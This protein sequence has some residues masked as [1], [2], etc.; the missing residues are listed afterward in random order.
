MDVHFTIGLELLTS[1]DWPIIYTAVAPKRP[2]DGMSM[3]VWIHVRNV[4]RKKA[5][6]RKNAGIAQSPIVLWIVNSRLHWSRV[7]IELDSKRKFERISIYGKKQLLYIV[8][9]KSNAALLFV[10]FVHQLSC[11][12]TSAISVRNIFSFFALRNFLHTCSYHT[13]VHT[14]Y[15]LIENITK[16]ACE[17]E[18]REKKK[19]FQCWLI[20]FKWLIRNDCD[21][22]SVSGLYVVGYFDCNFIFAFHIVSVVEL[23]FNQYID[24]K[25]N[26]KLKGNIIVSVRRCVSHYIDAQFSLNMAIGIRLN[27][28]IA[29]YSVLCYLGIATW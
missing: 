2:S 28:I 10:H 8:L 11:I 16:K 27:V 20:S 22:C 17:C 12:R 15:N 21:C 1:L 18:L 19:R 23:W 7:W 3:W 25:R 6:G 26:Y 29:F 14:S 5:D 9:K 24:Y 4:R 13:F